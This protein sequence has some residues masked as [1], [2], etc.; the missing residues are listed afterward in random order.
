MKT[1]KKTIL[2]IVAALIV[3]L[4]VGLCFMPRDKGCRL[5]DNVAAK[6]LAPR[7]GG[8]HLFDAQD[9]ISFAVSMMIARDMPRA[10]EELEITRATIDYFVKGLEDA[11]PADAT[12]EAIAYAHGVVVGASAM[13]MLDEANRAIY[14]S[15]TTKKVDRHIFLEGLKAMAYGDNRTMS[16]D[17]AY[18]Y[19]NRTIFRLPSEDFIAKNRQRN[20]VE[21]L[22]SGVQVKIERAGTG[23]IATL[24]SKVGYIYKASF[25]NG[26]LV[27][28]SRGEVVETVVGCLLPGL[29]EVFTTFPVGTKC[30]VYIPWKLA[31]GSRGS[32]RVPPYSA[33]VYD[34]EIVKIIKK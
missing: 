11:F 29:A 17:A 25:I 28:S 4:S 27:E 26:N 13:D 34:V 7:D 8:L 10:I 24:N 23:A 30:K 18:D 20:G 32:N 9:S 14:Q 12:S 3:Y 15:D 6:E 1:E 5:S 22:P 21:T 16:V 31:Y 2:I 19:Y 33:L